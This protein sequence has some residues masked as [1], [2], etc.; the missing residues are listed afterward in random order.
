MR[1]RY[2]PQAY[3]DLRSIKDYIANDLSSPAAALRITEEIM[4]RCTLLLEQPYLG[5]SLAAKICRKTDLRYL[6]CG[7]RLLFYRLDGDVVS[8]V[9]ILDG[10]SD[11]LLILFGDKNAG[12]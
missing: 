5:A 9:R 10:R 4:S 3:H 7:R 11:Y 6:V 8:I 2:T 12:K 1:L